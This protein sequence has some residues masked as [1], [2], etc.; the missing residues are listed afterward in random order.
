MKGFLP[1]RGGKHYLAKKIVPLIERIPHTCYIE[2]FMGAA[3]VFFRRTPARVEV[4]NDLN[5]ELVTLFRV[6]Q[7]H[8]DEFLRQFE[9][10][11]VSREE[12]YRLEKMPPEFLTDI[13]RAVRFYTLQKMS[14]AGRNWSRAFRTK[15]D[16]PP[17]LNLV[18]MTEELKG[19]RQRL[20]RVQIEN[21][22][23]EKCIPRYDREHSFFYIDPPYYGIEDYY[24]KN[25]FERAAF[26]QLAEI[27]AGLKGKFLLSLN[28][29][30]EVRKIFSSFHIA[31]I[32][33]RYPSGNHSPNHKEHVTELLIS[34]DAIAP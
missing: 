12:F 10:A 27:L 1:W 19:I 16:G 14:F 8:L 26:E 2:P 33:H 24:G 17:Q 13:Q 30:P 31:E 22:P 34:S 20:A 32:S 23:W 18:R 25:L 5:S 11:L 28:D 3:H 29:V 9:W 7:W 21:L 6:L 15:T 4:L